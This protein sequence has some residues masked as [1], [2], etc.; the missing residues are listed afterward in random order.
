MQMMKI[1]AIPS[2]HLSHV[3][4][5]S[6]AAARTAVWICEYPYRTMRMEGPSSEECGDCPVFQAMHCG[7][8]AKAALTEQKRPVL[9][10]VA[11]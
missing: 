8:M 1:A 10:P 2:C 9:R 3:S 4:G 5:P 7:S 6:P 11:V